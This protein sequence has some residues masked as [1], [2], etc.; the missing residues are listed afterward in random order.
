[1][2]SREKINLLYQA[3]IESLK[4]YSAKE[5]FEWLIKSQRIRSDINFA[6]QIE[7]FQL[8]VVVRPWMNI[9]LHCEVRGFVREAELNCCSQYFTDC[10]FPEV[11][12]ANMANRIKDFFD[13][14][15]KDNLKKGGLTSYIIDFAVV[16]ND[17]ILVLEL[18]PFDPSTSGCLFDWEKDREIIENGPFQF[19]WVTDS[20]PVPIDLPLKWKSKLAA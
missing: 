6:L 17:K 9:P 3:S 5:A 19:R 16:S 20:D 10:F 12:Y 4:V 13:K 18:N 11:D 14:E 8:S 2:N 15:I 1:M 7:P